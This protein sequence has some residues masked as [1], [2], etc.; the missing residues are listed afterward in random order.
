MDYTVT[1]EKFLCASDGIISLQLTPVLIPVF[2]DFELTRMNYE[3]KIELR[4]SSFKV[5]FNDSY[6]I[7]FAFETFQQIWA[8]ISEVLRMLKNFRS[9]F[10]VKKKSTE[11]INTFEIHS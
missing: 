4:L 10:K 7:R 1:I 5:N 8:V 6:S 3:K 11:I 2:T 9:A